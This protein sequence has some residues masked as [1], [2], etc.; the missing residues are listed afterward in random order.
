M[1][2]VNAP[3]L[4]KDNVPEYTQFI[5]G[6]VKAFVP[7][8]HENPELFDLVATYQGHSHSKSCRKY[9][10]EKCQ[11]H[12]GTFFTERTIVS[13]PLPNHLPDTVKNNILNER[14]RILS[15][16]KN[17]ID[18][19]FDTRKRNIFHP[20]KENFDDIPGIKNILAELKL[21]EEEYYGA[22]SILSDF[23][24]QIHLKRKPNACFI[25]N[26][27][28]D[29]LQAWKA[30]TDIQPVFNHYKAVTCI[31]TYFSKAEDETSEAMKQTAKEELS[32]NKSH[33]EK[34]KAIAR[35]YATK[36]ECSV[37][38]A[39]YLVI[40]ELWLRKI[41]PKVIFLNSNLPEER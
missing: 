13:L 17:H 38:E 28:V 40:P 24:F 39:V 2:I 3:I 23:D 27:F 15:M 14:E 11:Y 35:A 37:Q 33:Y 1:W 22:L 25:N 41:F 34:M 8:I 32:G 26:F 30:N 4:S 6:V 29:G 9:K 16:V 5:D 12:F 21:T 7:D 20:Q 18:T 10:N 31:C 19:H 36:R